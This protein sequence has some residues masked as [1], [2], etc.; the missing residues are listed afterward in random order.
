MKKIISI[1]FP[2]LALSLTGCS[3]ATYSHK[4]QDHEGK[5]RVGIT[6][7]NSNLDYIR[8]YPDVGECIDLDYKDNGYTNNALLMQ[9]ALNNKILEFPV[10]PVT[11]KL[12]RE[13]WVS[14]KGNIAIRM[15][16]AD[17]KYDTVSFKPRADS[18]YYVTGVLVSEYLPRKL[19]VMEVYKN[20]KGFYDNKEV[21]SM[22]LTNCEDGSF[23]MSKF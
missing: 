1:I 13:F 18:Y 2:L 5:Q 15:I 22:G 3:V 20:E 12:R 9:T 17:G 21:Y 4:L 10:T 7:D 8:V 6:F 23:R 11:S 16:R 19:S 14:A